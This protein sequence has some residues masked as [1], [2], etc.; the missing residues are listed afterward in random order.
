MRLTKNIVLASTNFDKLVE[1]RELL[2][3]NNSQ[4]SIVPVDSIVRNAGVLGKVE[5]FATYRENA[6]AKA[7]LANQACHYPCLADDSGL[8]IEALG[9][10]PGARSARFAT[11]TDKMT[12][13]QA[14]IDK[15]LSELKGVPLDK[16]RAKFVCS[17]ALVIE[18]V[19]LESTGTIEGWIAEAPTGAQGFG[20][21]PI[22]LPDH[23]D[24]GRKTFAELGV[25]FKNRH[26]HRAVAFSKL[27]ESLRSHGIVI[28]RV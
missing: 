20:Y 8:E 1:F 25:D 10:K 13:D 17:L 9:G 16:R 27:M 22:F 28:A 7:R 12:Q 5:V 6:A 18:G 11:P 15:V 14:N 2:K 24:A 19:L 21:D 26:S 4:Q 3:L 23:A